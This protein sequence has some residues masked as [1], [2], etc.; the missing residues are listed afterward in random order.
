MVAICDFSCFK[1]MQIYEVVLDGYE[2]IIH[3]QA[4]IFSSLSF[5]VVWESLFTRALAIVI[6]GRTAA[7]GTNHVLPIDRRGT[8][9]QK[10]AFY[11][12]QGEGLVSLGSSVGHDSA[13]GQ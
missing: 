10:S 3:K 13:R 1:S 12:K 8:S 2:V 4:G 9:W 11:R 7:R 6:L 5:D